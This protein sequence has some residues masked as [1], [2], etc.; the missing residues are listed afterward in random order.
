M[1]EKYIIEGFN[2]FYG[3]GVIELNDNRLTTTWALVKAIEYNKK[4][5]IVFVSNTNEIDH[6]SMTNSLKVALNSENI[7]LIRIFVKDTNGEA[8]NT[9]DYEGKFD[10]VLDVNNKKI[11]GS[12]LCSEE[13]VQ[14]LL[15]VTNNFQVEDAG[16][17]KT[18]Y[19][20]T[21]CIIGV[22]ILMFLI[23]AVLSKNIFYSNKDVLIEL[24]A[25]YNELISKGEYYRFITSMFLH[26]GLLHLALN[27]YSLYSV[28]PLVERIYGKIKY[29]SIYFISG[30]TASIFSYIFS[31]SVS[32]G[33]SGAIFGL[34]GTTLIFAIK[35]RNNLGSNFLKNVASVIVIN[36]F[37]GF[38][39]PNIDNYAHLGGLIG[40]IIMSLLLYNIKKD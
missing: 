17:P 24:G 34:L 14:E 9:F 38:S 6:I 3:Y 39:L 12:A 23:T 32:I 22:N 11:V 36:L 16:K 26:G 28:G 21:L 8:L 15:Y 13:V 5:V 30:I 10:L 27:M 18:E 19:L 2:K 37:I 29:L 4:R 31:D 7:E 35:M 33:A 20:I 25:K 1:K 40:G